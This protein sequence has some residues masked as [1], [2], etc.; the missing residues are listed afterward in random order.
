MSCLTRGVDGRLFD[1]GL[2]GLYDRKIRR[3]TV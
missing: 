3:G 2:E 1:R